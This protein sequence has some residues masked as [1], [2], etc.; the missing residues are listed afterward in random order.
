MKKWGSLKLRTQIQIYYLIA[1][2]GIVGIMG[3]VLFFS[4]SGLLRKEAAVTAAMAIDKS[5]HQLEM[6]IDQLKGLSELLAENPQ[7]YR[8][9]GQPHREGSLQASDRADIEVLI[10]SILQA[11]PEIASIIL[12]GADGRLLSNETQLNM[13]YSGRISEQGWYKAI[14]G[15]TMPV[16]TSVRMQ[17]FSMDRDSWVV[18]MGRELTDE[19]GKSIGVLRIDLRYHAIEAILQGISLGRHGYSFILND[20]LQVVYHHDPAFFQEEAKRQQ[21]LHVMERDSEE[22]MRE[23]RMTH[24]YRLTNADWLLVGVVSLDGVV[25]M[26]NE[27]I[28]VLW[29]MGAIL[30]IAILGSSSLFAGSVSRPVRQLE[31]AMARVEQGCLD[32]EVSAAGSAEIESLSRNFKSMLDKIRNLMEDVRHKE[33]SLRASEL[34]MLHSQINPHFLYNT[35]DTIVWLAEFGNM[36]RVVAVSKSMARYFRLSLHGGSEL[37]TVRDELEHVRQYLIIQ[38]ERYQDKLSYEIA[39]DESL[40]ETAV[41]KIILQPLVENA[42]HHGIRKLSK[43]GMIR[44]SA[45]A[46]GEK[47]LLS[48]T[49]NGPGFDSAV[50]VHRDEHSRLGGVGL[51]NVDERIRLYYGEGSGMRISSTPGAGTT[52]T[53]LLKKNSLS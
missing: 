10:R 7:V 22:L 49:D 27:I 42:I 52:V 20:R 9:F 19:K 40:L 32:I 15:S 44:V 23:Q 2:L 38:K 29:I 36:E 31:K 39:A 47:L 45:V 34:K 41:P 17:E 18:S 53:L 12:I 24:R 3:A 8:Y 25:Q 1:S 14:K 46:E 51:Q 13:E 4:T 28:V 30:L 21:L 43:G 35:L 16:L 26:Q 50:P 37:T 48:V 6:Y 11:N 5:G 33:R